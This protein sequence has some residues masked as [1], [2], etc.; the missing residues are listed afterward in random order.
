MNE[1]L[2][3]FIISFRTHIDIV[4]T[5]AF[6][7]LMLPVKIGLQNA[8]SPFTWGFSLTPILQMAYAVLTI[9]L[10]LFSAW[11]WSHGTCILVLF[12]A[13]VI[14]FG[15]T[16]L[17]W[18]GLILIST[19]LG[20]KVDG[21]VMAICVALGLLFIV[22]TGNWPAA[23]LSI[24]LCGI[25]VVIAFSLGTA[26]GVW[27]AHSSRV[28]AIVRPINDTLQTMPLFVILI[29]FVMVFKIGD[30]TALLAIIAYSIVPAIR[31]SEHGLRSLPHSI[32]ESALMIG[33]S[34]SQLLWQVKIPLALPI[35]MLGLNQ[36][37]LYGIAMLVIA[38]LVGAAGLEQSV[39]I[40]LT[41]G[42]VGEGLI[43][44]LGMAIIA[45]IADRITNGWSRQRQ[46][47]LG[48]SI[49]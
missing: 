22:V 19:L 31:Y 49:Q 27:A 10:A 16:G 30:F 1:A 14:Y 28:S 25:A 3:R 11:R 2:S 23:I 5:A 38:A 46:A 39:Y 48:L 35:L 47:A 24:Y 7:F 20:Y 41:D 44:G 26:I 37:I 8:I 29:P 33:A 12:F 43:A 36:T 9:A 17:P 40:A 21:Y 15:L 42:N 32:I 34:P 18:F 45:I 13:L 6:Y 4:K